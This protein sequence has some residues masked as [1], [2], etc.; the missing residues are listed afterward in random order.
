MKPRKILISYKPF[1]IVWVVLVLAYF[2]EASNASTCHHSQASY[3][4][5]CFGTCETA[6][7]EWFKPD[8]LSTAHR[9]L[10]F[11]TKVTVTNKRNNKT[12]TITVND[13]GPYAGNGVGH[14]PHSTRDLD[15]S[16]GAMR[17]LGGLGFGVIP[18][19]YCY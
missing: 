16:R 15:L 12:I 3:Y 1:L 2:F 14:R 13:R 6:S 4:E 19:E 9:T 17:K 5:R 10:P 18:V 7:G 8:G 11:G